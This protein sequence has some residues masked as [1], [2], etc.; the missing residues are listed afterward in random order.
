[1]FQVRKRHGQPLVVTSAPDHFPSR[2]FYIT[3]HSSGLR[4]LVDTGVLSRLHPLNVNTDTMASSYRLSIVH[5]L[6]LTATNSL[7]LT[8]GY[9]GLFDGCLSLLMFKALS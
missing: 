6:Q 8:W 1:M 5:P 9:E 7:H 3:N 4:Y 2:L